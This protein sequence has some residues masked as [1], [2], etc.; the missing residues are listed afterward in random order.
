MVA[1]WP[2]KQAPRTS[3]RP[4]NRPP[5][6][7]PKAPET[8]PSTPGPSAASKALRAYYARLQ[9]DLLVRGLLRTDGGGPDTPYSDIDVIRNFERI[10]F[11]DEY[12]RGGG[13]RR[14]DGTP[15][16]LK[17]WVQP[18]RIGVEFGASV[19]AEQRREDSAE[20]ARYAARL[21]RITGH[22][23]SAGA[24]DPNFHVF[25]VSEDDRK[26][27]K[28]RI[29]QIVPGVNPAALALFDNLPRAIHCFVIAFSR[30]QGGYEYAQ[31]IALIRAEHPS[32]LRRSCIHEEIAQGLGLANDSPRARPSIFNDDD[33]FA[34][35]T[36]HDEELL[37][38]LYDPRLRPGMT[39]EEARPIFSGL[40][41]R[42][43][44]QAL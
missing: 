28:P 42:Q 43:I 4:E 11:Y 23:I 19:P 32:L 38:L 37:R 22:P 26:T 27:L 1:D 44:G 12:A 14:S 13:L 2:T 21:G 6:P 40:A 8:E 9:N 36:T 5:Q 33:E 34:L 41:T 31:A 7:A 10:A 17:R 15:G 20:V 25:I 18:V 16:R 3:A 39:L 24:S 30:T 35:L 29:E